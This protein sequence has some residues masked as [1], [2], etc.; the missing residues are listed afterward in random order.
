MIGPY[1]GGIIIDMTGSFFMAMIASSSALM[2]AAI[3]ML[4]PNRLE[5]LGK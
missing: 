5:Y 3:L 1:L 4:R 2:V